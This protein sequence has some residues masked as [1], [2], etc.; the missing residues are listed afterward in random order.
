MQCTRPEA[1]TGEYDTLS[2]RCNS[3]SGGEHQQPLLLPSNNELCTCVSS[4]RS[5]VFNERVCAVAAEFI[6]LITSVCGLP[7]LMLYSA[8]KVAD[9][10]IYVALAS[11]VFIFDCC[12][13]A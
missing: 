10:F 2:D 5:E 12:H 1:P 6:L 7:W 9:Y 11:S 3:H 13:F 4:L 8:F